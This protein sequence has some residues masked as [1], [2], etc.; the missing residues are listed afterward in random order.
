[1]RFSMHQRQ[2]IY[3]SVR[4]K[5]SRGIRILLL[6]YQEHQQNARR[7]QAALNARGIKK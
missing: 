7:Y 3:T 5:I 6:P 2:L 1:M 4:E